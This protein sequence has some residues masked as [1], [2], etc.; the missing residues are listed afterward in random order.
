MTAIDATGLLSL[1][2][3]AEKIRAAGRTL[4]ICGARPQ[5]AKLIRKADFEHRIGRENICPNI[6]AALERAAQLR[7]EQKT[8]TGT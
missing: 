4:I 7:A 8:K 3:F 6:K 5:P 2:E 1:E